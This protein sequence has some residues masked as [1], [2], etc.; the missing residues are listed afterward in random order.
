MSRSLSAVSS[1]PERVIAPLP[2]RAIGSGKRRMI[3]S[4]VMVLPEPDSPAMATVSPGA[5]SKE[6]S[7]TTGRRPSGVATSVVRLRTERTGALAD[8][9]RPPVRGLLQD[10]PWEVERDHPIG[11]V[12]DLAD[13]EVGA[14]RAEHVGVD[15]L[16][17]VPSRQ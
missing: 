10:N 12:D 13:P 17:F 11:L 15:R 16:H 1:R 9:G 7:M 2:I 3:D 4:A 8:D 6:R 14:D 5:T